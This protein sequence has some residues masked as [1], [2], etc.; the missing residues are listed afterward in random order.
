MSHHRHHHHETT[1]NIKLAF[2]IN[3]AFCIIEL[4]GGIFTNSIAIMSD[5]LHD[6]G[7]SISLGLS[8]M[9]QKKSAKGATAKYSYGFKRLSVI[10]ATIN[11]IVL[12][13]GSTIVLIESVKRIFSPAEVHAEGML[14][15]AI[16]GIAANGFAFL[17]TRGGKNINQKSVSLHLL[18]DVMGWVAVL[19]VSVIMMFVDLPI[20]DPLL[21]IGIS[22]FIII[23]IIR[24]IKYI[25]NIVMQ[26]VPEGVNIEKLERALK[27]IDG[28]ENV[29]DIHV[30]TLDGESHI[31]AAH[32]KTA[33]AKNHLEIR[34][35]ARK[36]LENFDII[37]STLEIDQGSNSCAGDCSL[38]DEHHHH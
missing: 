36:I 30:W 3:F 29:H 18:E 37:H 32:L 4:I 22:I 7:D 2:F 27:K 19:I 1:K 14:I 33:S 34:S 16:I 5:A 31:L 12:A 11:S 9:F 20:L 6:L 35:Q 23:N 17:R 13:V 15:L 28:V 21:S 10:S 26:G 38:K 24:N 8:W 25:A